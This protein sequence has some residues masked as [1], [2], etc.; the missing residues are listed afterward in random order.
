MQKIFTFR[1]T[2]SMSTTNLFKFA[3]FKILKW[4][5]AFGFIRKFPWIAEQKL[6]MQILVRNRRMRNHTILT[7]N[8]YVY[9][10]FWINKSIQDKLILFDLENMKKYEKFY[11]NKGN[12]EDVKLNKW[13]GMYRGIFDD[14]LIYLLFQFWIVGTFFAGWFKKMPWSNFFNWIFRNRLKRFSVSS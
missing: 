14:S 8:I 13:F 12:I 9:M 10:Y 4:H 11:E 1:I 7:T 6:I 2:I 5:F 3:A